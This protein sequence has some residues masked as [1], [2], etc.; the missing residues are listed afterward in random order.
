[1]N[2]GGGWL[3]NDSGNVLKIKIFAKFG[4]DSSLPK[5]AR[6]YLGNQ[7]DKRQTLS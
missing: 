3:N 7:F 5:Y 4:P 6:V 1:M 2:Q